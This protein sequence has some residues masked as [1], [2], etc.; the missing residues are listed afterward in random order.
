MSTS[1]LPSRKLA[2]AAGWG[3]QRIPLESILL[4][5][6]SS[7]N[8]L[9]LLLVPHV[10]REEFWEKVVVDDE[11]DR[12]DFARQ[13]GAGGVLVFVDILAAA[14]AE[15]CFPANRERSIILRVAETTVDDDE[16]VRLSCNMDASMILMVV[17]CSSTPC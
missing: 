7:C 1:F 10:Y 2:A 11:K 15:D 3:S 13:D 4:S 17:T 14:A 6:E 16:A 5:S 8:R 12:L 9:P